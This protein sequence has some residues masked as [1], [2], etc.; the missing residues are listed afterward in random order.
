MT[1]RE[2]PEQYLDGYD[3]ILTDVSATGRRLT[4]EEIASRRALGEQAAEA[5]HGL[6]ALIS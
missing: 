6:R 5:G 2:M 3:R 1:D 4:R